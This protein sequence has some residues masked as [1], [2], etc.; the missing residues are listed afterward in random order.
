MFMLDLTKNIQLSPTWQKRYS[1]LRFF[2]YLLFLASAS[3]FSYKVLFPSLPFYFFFETPN[4]TKNTIIEPRL[5]GNATLKKG[6]VAGGNLV[7]DTTL[8]SFKGE[9]S[10]VKVNFTLEKNS[11]EIDSGTITLRKSYRA[12]FYP[13]GDPITAPLE[14][15]S[16]F[17]SGSL[18]SNGISAYITENNNIF[19]INNTITFESMGFDWA[20]VIPA[21]S[22]EIGA[23]V[24]GKLFTI[25]S[26]H[27]DGTIFVT[28]DKSR[29]YLIE[30][31]KKREL[32]GQA[33]IN[34]YLKR[35]PILVDE[36]SLETQSQCDLKATWSI[37]N[38][39]YSCVVP[40]DNLRAMAGNDY[41]YEI[42]FG[43]DIEVKEADATF[44]KTL[45]WNNLIS[46]L[47]NIKNRI[48]YGGQVQ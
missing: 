38:K 33:V 23:Y 44:G 1:I 19:P 16:K 14:D 36:K 17:P 20:D 18:L 29:Y 35:N 47:S 26:P 24:K 2:V 8:S 40:L 46:S 43:D 5:P 28:Q 15:L 41:Q 25:A 7:F 13:E 31:G 37:F 9:F 22:D 34:S 12:F 27:P 6:A 45:N 42:N 3:Y 39:S 48:L 4:A 32:V 21:S 10:Q 30:G 11:P